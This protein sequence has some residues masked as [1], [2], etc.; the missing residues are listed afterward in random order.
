[1]N[2]D[3]SILLLAML[4]ATAGCSESA[5][6]SSDSGPARDIGSETGADAGGSETT[7]PV[8]DVD[9]RPEEV[10]T[11][12]DPGL[13]DADTAPEPLSLDRVVPP[14]GPVEGGNRVRVVGSGFT[15]DVALY[16]G[17]QR[18]DFQFS[19][20]ALVGEVPPGSGPGSVSVKVVAE[21]ESRAV[22]SDAY[23]YVPGVEID[24]VAPSRIPVEGG[25]EITIEG[26][27]FE[28]SAA[29]SFDRTSALRVER[30]D[31]GELRAIAPP[32]TRG[33]A[34]VRVTTRSGTAVEEGAIE[35]VR[36]LEIERVR[37][38]AGSTAGGTVATVEVEGL[39]PTASVEFGGA[40]ARVRSVDR[41][42]G[43]IEVE[44]PPGSAGLVD[45][46]VRSGGD[47]ALATDS[48]LYD[49]GQGERLATLDP[50]YG[51][52]AGGTEVELI[53]R[54]LG[55][56]GLEVRFGGASATVRESGPTYAR[57]ETPPGSPGTV[58]VVAK[59]GGARLGTLTDGF[60]YRR[61]IEIDRV[62]P[63]QGPAAGG[64]KVTIEGSG[65]EEAET[66]SFG[67]L[68]A[69]FT[70]RTDDEIRATTPEHGAGA[71]DVTVE[72]GG[73]EARLEEGFSYTTGLEVWGFQPV[74][75]SVAGGTFVRV[76]GEGFSGRLRADF[77]GKRARELRR[78]DRNN[79]VLFTPSQDPGEAT[80]RVEKE[81]ETAEGPYPFEF[82]DPTG[83]FG[84]A[85]GARID[86]AVNVTVLSQ[87]G[88]P[89]SEAFVMLSTR[90]DTEFTGTT[91]GSGQVT[92]SGPG[93]TGPQTVTAVARGF[94]STTVREV[95]AENL[96]L[97]L[98]PLDPS[99]GGGGGG[100]GQP[101]S[102]TIEGDVRAPFKLADPDVN[103]TQDMAVVRTTKESVASRPREPGDGSVVLGEGSYQIDS[104]IGDMAVVAFCGSYDQSTERF[105]P[106]YIGVKR[107]L[108]VSDGETER[109]D[110]VCDIPLDRSLEVKIQN[111]IFAPT[112]PDTNVARVHWDFGFGGVIEAPTT[113]T[114]VGN[115]LEVENQPPLEGDLS[116]VT[117]TVEAGS[118]T[119]SSSPSSRTQKDDIASYERP[120][121]MAPLVDVPEPLS[122]KTGE[123]LSGRQIRFQASGP[124]YPE[125]YNVFLLD[126]QG[127]PFWRYLMGGKETTVRLPEFPDLSFLP[128]DQRP[129]PDRQNPVSILIF[130]I[131]APDL[132]FDSFTYRDLSFSEWRGYSTRRWRFRME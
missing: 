91:D 92:L 111:P 87:N 3:A 117:L 72:G 66:V 53:G 119:G 20:G 120:A 59:D 106:Q 73:L 67:G 76:R 64:T 70:V 101:P 74:R 47:A 39:G 107:F 109:A 60:E 63:A 15:D 110:L 81:E 84:G 121:V 58:D 115:L 77:D 7:G 10:D 96:T 129:E 108:S 44:T 11:A 71:V 32:G 80:L 6:R 114:G 16:F 98:R 128:P 55:A 37:P 118:F 95:N 104:R 112:G 65:F 116:D 8:D 127:R 51:S 94:A 48:F 41:N 79:L 18:A 34:D 25:T 89:I 105:D 83:R 102:A 43:E 75:G 57:V 33:P 93:V 132:T 54:G 99:G 45:V 35:Y 5:D 103:Q 24:R 14:R 56:S 12:W 130:G 68:P 1:M 27:G 122:P 23:E 36:P 28:E 123:I 42:S 88:G 52:T 49:D 2:R 22:L 125:M 90:S 78:I 38:A 124:P 13:S 30:L 61:A 19:S 126:R 46:A 85:S 69:S 131:D 62:T 100:G 9:R 50:S 113:A 17:S 40:A 29:V 31:S 26:Q 21:D 97:L 82:F 86:G 4:V